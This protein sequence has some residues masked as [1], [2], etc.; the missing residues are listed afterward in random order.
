MRYLEEEENV[1]SK[2]MSS[3]AFGEHRPLDTNNTPEGQ[4]YNR[5][6]DI[7]L[8]RDKVYSKSKN[9]KIDRPLPDEEWR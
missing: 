2:R 8:L 7:V 4:A 9:K 5:R 3:V 1:E 6:V